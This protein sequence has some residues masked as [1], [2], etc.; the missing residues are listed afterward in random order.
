M[1]NDLLICIVHQIASGQVS[2][3]LDG[4]SIYLFGVASDVGVTG[5][6]TEANIG[7][8]IDSMGPEQTSKKKRH[9]INK[10]VRSINLYV[11]KY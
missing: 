7:E 9:N 11:N 6:S 1:Y 4:T 5:T 8:L 2:F 10:A 3:H